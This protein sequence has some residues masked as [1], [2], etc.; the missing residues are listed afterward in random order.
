MLYEPLVKR[1][2][3][4]TGLLAPVRKKSS[5]LDLSQT[6]TASAADM[7]R[8][9]TNLALE[10]LIAKRQDSL[11]EPGKRNGAWVKYKINK[12]QESVVGGYTPG[13]PFDAVI[14]GCYHGDK[15]FYA[16]KVR[17]GSVP[18]VRR[19]HGADGHAENWCLSIRESPG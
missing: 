2:D 8:A 3:A 17:A 9:I 12:G 5:A 14:V 1:R 13:N 15:L 6:V 7:I 16:G 19:T 18:H 4:L 10:G 11:Y